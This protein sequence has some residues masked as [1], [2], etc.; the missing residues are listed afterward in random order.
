MNAVF[1]RLRRDTRL[2]SRL[3]WL[4]PKP[5]VDDVDISESS[6]RKLRSE[7]TLLAGVSS[8]VLTVRRDDV[9]LLLADV[10]VRLA[11]EKNDVRT[12]RSE[13]CCG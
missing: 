6:S 9:M 4:P 1:G 5:P 12:G 10:G 2:V 7:P 11:N 13:V 8:T 3:R